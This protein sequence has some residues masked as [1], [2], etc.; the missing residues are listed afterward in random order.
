MDFLPHHPGGHPLLLGYHYGYKAFGS[1]WAIMAVSVVSILI[2]EPLMVWLMFHEQPSR[3]S[4][5]ALGLGCTGLILLLF[6]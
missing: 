1:M 2:V 4:L 5:I 6:E 3:I